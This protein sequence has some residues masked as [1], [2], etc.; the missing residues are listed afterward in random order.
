MASRGE[1]HSSWMAV[2]EEEEGS[3]RRKRGR[4]MCRGR[5]MVR[6]RR[7]R[8]RRPRSGAKAQKRVCARV[9]T[10]GVEAFWQW[11]SHL[12]AEACGDG[13]L[14]R[15]E[16]PTSLA[17]RV[18]DSVHVPRRLQWR[19]IAWNLA[20]WAERARGARD[21]PNAA[22]AGH[23]P[24]RVRASWRSDEAVPIDYAASLHSEPAL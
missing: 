7:G 17:H 11:A 23:D 19:G 4:G 9:P 8:Q 18:T 14:V 12:R 3:R 13:R 16:Q 15:H 24:G 1:N 2:A 21:G 6:G 20:G 5:G 22:R 10:L